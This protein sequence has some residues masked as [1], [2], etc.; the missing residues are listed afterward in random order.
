MTAMIQGSQLRNLVLGNAPVSKASGA[1][2]GN[3]TINCFTVAGGEV[4]ITALWLKA[5]TAITTDGG[6]L[7]VQNDP[8]TGDTVTIVTATDLGT[9][10]TAVGTVVGLD[11]GTTAA[12]KFLRGGRANLNAVVTTGT[13]DL[14]GA[15]SVN[16]AVTVYC[17]WVPLTDGATLVA[18]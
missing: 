10:D 6:T 4:L 2:S 5:T 7:A 17:T 13:V 3:P 14:V 11:S 15:S 18:A 12:S 8:S 1:I 16:G 9:T